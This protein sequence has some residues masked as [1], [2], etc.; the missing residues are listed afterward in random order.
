MCMMCS[1]MMDVISCRPR[2]ASYSHTF[3][4]T[5]SSGEESGYGAKG[6]ALQNGNQH[7]FLSQAEGGWSLAREESCHCH[8]RTCRSAER[9]IKLMLY[10]NKYKKVVSGGIASIRI[11]RL[12]C[13]ITCIQACACESV[14]LVCLHRS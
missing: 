10:I 5:C 12:L 14:L 1:L 4:R 3:M 8:F 2:G 13:I 7:Y 11:H 9:M 6:T